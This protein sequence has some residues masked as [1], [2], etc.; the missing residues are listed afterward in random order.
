[1]LGEPGGDV[2]DD[3]L[4]ERPLGAKALTEVPCDCIDRPSSMRRM[5]PPRLP[6]IESVCCTSPVFRPRPAL[7]AERRRQLHARN[8]RR[9]V[10]R[11]AAGRQ[12][13]DD[14]LA[15]DALLL[16]LWTSTTGAAPETVM[17]SSTPPTRMS[18]F[19]VAVTEPCSTIPSRFTVKNLRV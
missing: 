13:V 11:R 16:P 14:F 1:L 5:S 10:E 6:W 18:A 15:E 12:R 19:T 4:D 9:H 8:Q 7:A 17:V 2:D 3:F